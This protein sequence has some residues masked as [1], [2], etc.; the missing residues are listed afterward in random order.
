MAHEKI[1]GN[2]HI[3]RKVK[4]RYKDPNV[5]TGWHLQGIVSELDEGQG[6]GK[7]V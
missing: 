5:R 6:E 1:W 7:W 2:K 3:P 4:N